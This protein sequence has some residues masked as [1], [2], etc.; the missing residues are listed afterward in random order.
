[1]SALTK[2]PANAHA[3]LGMET[4]RDYYLHGGNCTVPI[5]L[6]HPGA[7]STNW[8]TSPQASHSARRSN[9]NPPKD[10]GPKLVLVRYSP[11]HLIHEE[12]VSNLANIDAQPIVWAREMGRDQDRPLIQY[13]HNR[14]AWLLEPDQS[15][16]NLT[17]YR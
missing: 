6:R 13:F 2:I 15:P 9:P 4:N 8:R 3:P 17:P 14:Q 10:P 16:P 7:R 12:W 1:M 5:P 11:D